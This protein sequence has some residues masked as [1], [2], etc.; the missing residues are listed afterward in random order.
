[1]E[2]AVAVENRNNVV[3]RPRVGVARKEQHTRQLVLLHISQKSLDFL[4]RKD[5]ALPRSDVDRDIGF[6]GVVNHAV[7][8]T[9]PF[10]LVDDTPR[11]LGNF[12]IGKPILFE[13]GEGVDSTRTIH[14]LLVLVLLPRLHTAFEFL[15]LLSRFGKAFLL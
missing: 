3:A 2:F 14:T 6:K 15:R 7:I 13:G 12:H 10:T 11:N 9:A 4:V 1:M 8:E 5:L